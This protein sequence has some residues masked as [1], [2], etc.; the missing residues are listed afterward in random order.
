MGLCKILLLGGMDN[1]SNRRV[2]HKILYCVN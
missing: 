2:L 1:I